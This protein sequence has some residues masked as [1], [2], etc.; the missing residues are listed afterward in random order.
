MP[1][2]TAHAIAFL[3]LLGYK[4]PDAHG[5]LHHGFLPRVDFTEIR[6]PDAAW[7]LIRDSLEPHFDDDYVKMWNRANPPQDPDPE[8]M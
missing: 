5:H 1:S 7:E 2:E 3:R 6:S 8:G 4:A